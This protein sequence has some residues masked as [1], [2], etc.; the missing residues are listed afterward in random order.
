VEELGEGLSQ[1]AQGCQKKPRE[2][3]NFAGLQRLNHQSK[4]NHGLES[5][6]LPHI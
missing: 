3:T 4:S 5:Q 6:I 1:T 2:A